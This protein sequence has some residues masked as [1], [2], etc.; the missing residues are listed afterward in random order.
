[1]NKTLDIILLDKFAEKRSCASFS[2]WVNIILYLSERPEM[3]NQPLTQSK[4]SVNEL[5]QESNSQINLFLQMIQNSTQVEYNGSSTSQYNASACQDN[6]KISN[7]QNAFSLF[8][9][10]NIVRYIFMGKQWKDV[11]NEF[12]WNN[13]PNREALERLEQ[14][15]KSEFGKKHLSLVSL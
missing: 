12:M 15:V 9:R 7:C 3:L 1:M 6:N 11:K 14:V 5:L 13:N 4:M 2:S 8:L 10:I